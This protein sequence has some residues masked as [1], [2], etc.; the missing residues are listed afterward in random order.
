MKEKNKKNK[1]I[2]L[3]CASCIILLVIVTIVVY[4]MN[5][6]KIAILG[7]HGVMP[8]EINTSGS[9]LIVNQE[10]FEK[11][12]KYLK[13]HGYKSMTL[14]EFNCWKNKECKK[15]HKSVLI[16]FDD[17]YM[18]NYL[19]AFELLKKYDMNAVVFYVGKNINSNEG[20]YMNKETI[21]KAKVEYP[22]IEFA[23]HSYGLHENFGK[24]YEEVNNDIMKMKDVLDSKYYAYP[25]GSFTD[26]YISA[27]KDNGYLLAFTFGPG[28][29][30]RKADI[31]DDNYKIPRLNISKDMPM[32]KFTLRLVLPV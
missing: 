32:Y 31:K 15:A 19:Y 5:E 25:H 13:K 27:L 10:D 4:T 18:D 9:K 24:T 11:Q 12:L 7:Y 2:L 26:E 17:G 23:S 16:T 14:S 8:K 3:L 1:I 28:K 22:N 29:N 30:H 6:N 21:E 20:Y